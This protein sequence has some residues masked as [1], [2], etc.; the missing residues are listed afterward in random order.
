MP[1]ALSHVSSPPTSR[2]RLFTV[3]LRVR[4]D[5]RAA[6][7]RMTGSDFLG[8]VLHGAVRSRWFDWVGGDAP[9]SDRAASQSASPANLSW[10]VLAPPLR[11]AVGRA[12]ADDIQFGAVLHGGDAA[13]W[14][15]AGRRLEA[16]YELSVGPLRVPVLAA[17]CEHRALPAAAAWT[18]AMTGDNPYAPHPATLALHWLTPL[19]LASRA[20]I[21]AGHGDAA[22]TLLATVR[23][24]HRRVCQLEPE[25]AEALGLRTTAW[26]FAEE[27]LRRA[28]ARADGGTRNRLRLLDWRYGSR[29]KNAPFGRS[30]PIGCQVFRVPVTNP[31]LGLLSIG[32]WLGVGEGASF[33]CGQYLWR[34]RLAGGERISAAVP[35][36]WAGLNGSLL[37]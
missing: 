12:T 18:P 25:W 37:A 7:L 17:H 30:G 6:A 16:L 5:L 21:E 35:Q 20:K 9:G 10:R 8:G 14:D 22:P 2:G 29:T 28:E 23:S 11:R 36:P 13:L 26:V 24:L 19:H 27:A 31:L 4:G 34:A 3:R 1:P 15:E 32:T 33:G